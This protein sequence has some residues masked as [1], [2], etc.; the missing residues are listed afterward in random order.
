MKFTFTN[1]SV[2]IIRQSTPK[3]R[4]YG[5]NFFEGYNLREKEGKRI[6]MGITTGREIGKIPWKRVLTH[7][8]TTMGSNSALKRAL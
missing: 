7:K 5:G 3:D 2:M 6:W 8:R 1:I 4:F